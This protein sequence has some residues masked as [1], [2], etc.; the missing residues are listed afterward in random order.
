M[1]WNGL[2]RS[3]GSS[4]SVCL[5]FGAPSFALA[6]GW[7]CVKSCSRMCDC[8]SGISS[9]LLSGTLPPPRLASGDMFCVWEDFQLQTGHFSPL[10][11]FAQ[12]LAGAASEGKVCLSQ[13]L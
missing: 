5:P 6:A 4:L 10:Y 13:P 9:S 11:G 1:G 7:V 12:L 8:N 3:Q 2:P